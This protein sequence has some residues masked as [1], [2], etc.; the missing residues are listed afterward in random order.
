MLSFKQKIALSIGIGIYTAQC[1]A[2]YKLY[3]ANQILTEAA[4]TSVN[5]ANRS[6]YL[7]MYMI[8]KCAESGIELTAF[9]QQVFANPPKLIDPENPNLFGDFLARYEESDM[10]SGAIEAFFNNLEKLR[11]EDEG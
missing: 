9:D 7:V 8:A 3:K 1:L 5:F 10:D 4:D 2:G 6:A 11:N